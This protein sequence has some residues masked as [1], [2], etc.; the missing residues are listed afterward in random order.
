MKTITLIYLITQIS[1]IFA[2]DAISLKF[3]NDDYLHRWSKENQHEFTPKDQD[4]LKKWNDMLTL[5]TYKNAKDGESLAAVANS[6]VEGYKLG[7]AKILKVDALP[8]TEEQPAEYLIAAVF[9]RP[10]LIEFVI[11]R[12]KLINDTGVSVIYSHRV[13]GKQSGHVMSDWMKA[14]GAK[15]EKALWSWDSFP[16]I[17]TLDSLNKAKK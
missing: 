4:D 8:K 12:F 3:N 2:Q 13:Y 1:V 16:S 17:E 10:T 6:V 11:A 15:L 7:G 14:N 5:I 9:P